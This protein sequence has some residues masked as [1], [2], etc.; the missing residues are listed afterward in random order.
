MESLQAD[1]SIERTG[2]FCTVF[3]LRPLTSQAFEWIEQNI[4]ENAQCFGNALAVEHR[5]VVD[6]LGGIR[7]DGLVIA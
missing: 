5:Y 3:L 6:V 2:R 4:P 7:N 1:F